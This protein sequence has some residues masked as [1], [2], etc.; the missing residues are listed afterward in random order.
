QFQ[1]VQG[2]MRRVE[3]DSRNLDVRRRQIA[4]DITA[5]RSNGDDVLAV[6]QVHRLDVD[7]RVFP[8]LGVDQAG[9]GKREKP[10]LYALARNRLVTMDSLAQPLIAR[11]EPSSFT[12]WTGFGY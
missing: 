8:D 1:I 12:G 7:D 4:Q 6:L 11:S 5:A 9:K 2:N 10:L 3:V